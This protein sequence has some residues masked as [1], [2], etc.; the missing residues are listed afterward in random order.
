MY[1]HFR[2][3]SARMVSSRGASFTEHRAAR[4]ASLSR[5]GF[6]ELYIHR[7]K[8]GGE[9]KRGKLVLQIRHAPLAFGFGFLFLLMLSREWGN[10]MSIHSYYGSFP[11]S[12]LFPT[13]HQEV[14]V[15]T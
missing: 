3:A 10:G 8:N 4:K 5:G 14:F 13:K 12:S 15:S 9:A 2:N 7:K 6:S 11:Y 1:V